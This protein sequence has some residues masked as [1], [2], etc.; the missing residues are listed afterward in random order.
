[1]AETNGVYRTEVTTT[2]DIGTYSENREPVIPA[3]SH[4]YDWRR[5]PT[6]D[7]AVGSLVSKVRPR[8]VAG[9]S[10]YGP[11]FN[12][13]PLVHAEEEN[14]DE[15]HYIQAARRERDAYVRA[16]GDIIAKVKEGGSQDA[17]ILAVEGIARLAL[18]QA[19]FS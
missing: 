9:L 13:D 12:G 19:E 2:E 11:Y 1:M 18:S 4:D 3:P 5:Q 10:L 17:V 8:H 7:E 15:W 6:T 16:L 14:I